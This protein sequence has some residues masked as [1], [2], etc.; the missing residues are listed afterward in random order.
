LIIENYLSINKEHKRRLR[1]EDEKFKQK[2]REKRKL[3]KTKIK[4]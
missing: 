3:D 2:L 4:N 1:E